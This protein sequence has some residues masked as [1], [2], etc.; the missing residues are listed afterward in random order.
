[1]WAQNN[2]LA[3][4][5][6]KEKLESS[7]FLIKTERNEGMMK[8]GKHRELIIIT[9]FGS[10]NRTTSIKRTKWETPFG[11]QRSC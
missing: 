9:L 1:M 6:S 8:Q 11:L 4:R 2:Y 3:T 5:V 10:N 7:E